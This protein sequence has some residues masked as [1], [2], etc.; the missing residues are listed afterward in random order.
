MD[1]TDDFDLRKEV[2]ILQPRRLPLGRVVVT[3]GAAEGLSAAD[4]ATAI[5]RHSVGDWG[6]LGE[7]DR[8]AN[9]DAVEHGGRVLS[10]Y[11]AAASG[12]RFWVITEAD[13]SVRLAMAD[14]W[15]ASEFSL[16]RS[17]TLLEHGGANSLRIKGFFAWQ[18][19]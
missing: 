5:R 17:T 8:E 15:R 2:V 14:G 1:D 4:I 16:A 10:A 19:V 18:L 11:T 13:R 12:E 7:H 9:T 6:D 3:S